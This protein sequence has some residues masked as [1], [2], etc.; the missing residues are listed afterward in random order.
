MKPIVVVG[1]INMDLVAGVQKRPRPG[2]TI[3]GQSF[4]EVPG[5]KGA[6]Q[7]VAAARLGAEVRM[8]GRVGADSFGQTLQRTLQTD[9]IDLT[10]VDIDGEQ[11]SGIA[12]ITV[13]GTGENSI[14][15]IPGANGTL[16]AEIVER[17]A[18]IIRSAGTLLVQLEVPLDAVTRALEIA[19]ASGVRTVLNPAPAAELPESIY[20]LVD[21]LIPNETELEYLTGIAAT[22]D[23]SLQQAANLLR[24]RGVK[25]VVV[26]LGRQ[27]SIAFS[28]DKVIRQPIYD[29]PRIDTTA[30]GDSFIA[31]LCVSLGEGHT[32]SR[33]LQFATK[34]AALTVSKAGAQSSL[35]TRA[36]V[37][38]A[39]PDER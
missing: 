31:G 14:I 2:E 36:A 35:P 3:T 16:T 30:A 6:N 15:V 34:V 27:G 8:I 26:T 18:S 28:E 23:A 24:N 39:Y 29:A 9:R 19:H 4:A 12:L 11:P 20:P 25:T 22:S 5:G 37:L 10:G 13:D 17:H 1:S 7:A 38:A 32:L 21:L 33:S